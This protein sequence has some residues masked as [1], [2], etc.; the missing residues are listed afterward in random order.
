MTDTNDR[1]LHAVTNNDV[2]LTELR[3]A[4]LNAIVGLITIALLIGG[5]VLLIWWRSKHRPEQPDIVVRI[6]KD[7]A[8]AVAS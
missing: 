1:P 3:R 4:K 7:A 5:A 2:E 6:V 8:T